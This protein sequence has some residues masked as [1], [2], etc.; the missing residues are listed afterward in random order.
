MNKINHL[1]FKRKLSLEFLPTETLLGVRVI[2][3]DVLCEDNEYRSIVG[4]EI[5]FIFFTIA[6][7]KLID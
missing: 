5:G 2:N 1:Q 4:L 3:C 7:V 6:Y